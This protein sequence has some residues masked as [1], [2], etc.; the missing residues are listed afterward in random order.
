[1]ASALLMV[2]QIYI[3]DV[4]FDNFIVEDFVDFLATFILP[5]RH[6]WYRPRMRVLM[7]QLQKVVE[8]NIDAMSQSLNVEQKST[9][10]HFLRI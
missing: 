7:L 6:Y 2:L 8:K 9:L 3:S 4:D 5:F 1:M 10:V